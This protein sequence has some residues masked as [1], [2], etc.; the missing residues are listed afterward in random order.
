MAPDDVVLSLGLTDSTA[1]NG[2]SGCIHKVCD[3]MLL[4]NFKCLPNETLSQYKNDWQND[5]IH[6]YN[7]IFA[8]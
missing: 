3:D 4:S 1:A 6:N 8:K 7:D 5:L 2:W